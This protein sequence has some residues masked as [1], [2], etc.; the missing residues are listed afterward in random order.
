MDESN[1][2]KKKKCTENCLGDIKLMWLKENSSEKEQN[3]NPQTFLIHRTSLNMQ[4]NV[5]S[6]SSALS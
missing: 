1:R 4:I 5:E 3:R 2:G 6:R